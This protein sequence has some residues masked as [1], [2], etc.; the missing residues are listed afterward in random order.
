KRQQVWPLLATT[1]DILATTSPG[2]T[3][4]LATSSPGKHA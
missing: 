4:N 3:K 2:D 1:G